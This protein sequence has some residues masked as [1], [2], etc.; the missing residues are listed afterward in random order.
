MFKKL[1]LLLAV[2]SSITLSAQDCEEFYLSIA[3]NVSDG[4]PVFV[5]WAVAAQ[6][7][8]ILVEGQ[9][10]F[11]INNPFFGEDLCLPPGCYDFIVEANEP[12]EGA[13]LS[14]FVDSGTGEVSVLSVDFTGAGYVL[15]FCVYE[16]LCEI[17]V[18]AT[19]ISCDTYIFDI[20]FV[21]AD[22]YGWFVNGELVQDNTQVYTFQAQEAGTYEIMVM[23]ETPQCPEGVFWVYDILVTEDCIGPD[24]ASEMFIEHECLEAYFTLDEIPEGQIEWDFGDGTSAISTPYVVHEYEEAG[25]YD[26]CATPIDSPCDNVV[27]TTLTLQECE[28]DPCEASIVIEPIDCIVY[29]FSLETENTEFQTDWFLNGQPIS[30]NDNDYITWYDVFEGE[31][32]ICVTTISDGCEQTICEWFFVEPCWDCWIEADYYQE[33]DC[34]PYQ[35]YATLGDPNAWVGWSVNGEYV[36]EGWEFVFTPEEPGAY[37]ICAFSE[38][39]QCPWGTEW[40]ESVFVP[41]GCFGADP[42]E[43]EIVVDEVQCGIFE[44]ALATENSTFI[45]EWYLDGEY[46]SNTDTDY[47]V[48]ADVPLGDHEI[49]VG[50]FN[51]NCQETVCV[52]FFAE[53]CGDCWIEYSVTQETDCSPFIFNAVAGEPDAWIGWYVDGNY[54]ADGYEYVFEPEAP[55]SYNVCAITESQLCP[56]GTEYCETVFVPEGCF[57]QPCVIDLITEQISCGQWFV[58]IEN[59]DPNANYYWYLGGEYLTNDIQAMTIPLPSNG[60]HELCILNENGECGTYEGCVTLYAEG[61]VE[62]CTEVLVSMTSWVEEGGPNYVH[63]TLYDEEENPLEASIAQFSINSPFAFPE[64]CLEEGCYIFEIFDPNAGLDSGNEDFS[65]GLGGILGLVESTI[66]VQDDNYIVFEFCV[67]PTLVDP[68]DDCPTEIFATV[69][70]CQ[71]FVEMP[72]ADPLDDVVW[73]IGDQVISGGNTLLWEVEENGVVD[74]C[75]VYTDDDCQ[76]EL[77]TVVTVYDCGL[78]DC[79]LFG[80]LFTQECGSVGFELYGDMPWG[81]QPEI[82]LDDELQ[83]YGFGGYFELEEGWHV[84]CASYESDLC[85][86]VVVWCEE[87]YVNSCDGCE[88]GLDISV[89][90][91]QYTVSADWLDPNGNHDWFV[92]GEPVDGTTELNWSA[93]ENGLYWVCVHPEGC[94]IATCTFVNIIDCSEDCIIEVEV[95]Q[96]DE[97]TFDFTAWGDLGTDVVWTVNGF[98]V[99]GMGALLDYTFPDYG[100]YEVCAAH[101]SDECGL[102]MECVN[103]VVA[104][105][106]ECTPVSFYLQDLEGIGVDLEIGYALEGLGYELEGYITIQEE[107][108][109]TFLQLCIPDGC[110]SLTLS[111]EEFEEAALALYVLVDLGLNVEYDIDF[112][113]QTATIEFGVNDDCIVSVQDEE[114]SEW[115]VY[116]N[117][118]N[119]AFNVVHSLELGTTWE[120]IDATGRIVKNGQFNG[121]VTTIETSEMSTGTYFLRTTDKGK[122]LIEQIQVFR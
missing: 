105:E 32:E 87:F 57:E 85:D 93:D 94:N 122:T 80:E 38:S 25:T 54:M 28:T 121:T 29:Q 72:E 99:D 67:E 114:K 13:L 30:F 109:S 86:E 106:I 12:F 36:G 112:I 96:V 79:E 110:Y 97:F 43:A 78:Q 21:D 115:M 100:T 116:P 103:V 49:C 40:C 60:E 69:D 45:T 120:I 65:V 46:I 14:P 8:D 39:Q 48:F 19:Q 84:I 74:I 108:G 107:C 71:I 90:G 68:E 1:Y 4:G 75:A 76:V 101:L 37:Q 44:F 9:A 41:E 18:V 73:F 98:E 17:D 22:W 61:C 66:T 111:L 58:Q 5:E 24:C 92:E 7:D 102:I 42:C 83:Y 91:C 77:C 82:Y 35:F 51:E 6:D 95:N 55:G 89:S 33:T 119:E 63:W 118:A 104:P 23:Y 20:F 113:N 15:E 56:W 117:P 27:C 52:D 64:F 62:E 31:N 47:V 3:S 11:S 2:F 26:V 81:I 88:G 59:P 10:Q 70:G 34:S 16:P 53:P 50:I